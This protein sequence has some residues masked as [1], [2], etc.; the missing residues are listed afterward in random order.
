VSKG[1]SVWLQAEIDRLAQLRDTDMRAAERLAVERDR[2]LDGRLD[3]AATAVAAAL[4]AAEK[5]VAAALAASEKAVGKAEIAQ[6]KVNETQNE[7]RGSLRDQATFQMPRSEAENTFR[8]LRGL[9]AAQ[10]AVIVELR[11]RLDI[12]PPSL[13][14][15]Q[16]RSDEELGHARGALDARS[17]LFAVLGTFIGIS[18]VTAAILIAITR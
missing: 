8:E 17:F 12:G 1:K 13:S 7:F 10:D 15:L 4:A 11:S 14:T 9:I 18:G 5:A 6:A 16:A 2:R 3:E